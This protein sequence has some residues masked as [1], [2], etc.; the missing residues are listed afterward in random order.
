VARKQDKKQAIKASL[1][2][3]LLIVSWVGLEYGSLL[4]GMDQAAEDYNQGDAEA[5]LKRY[6]DI[7]AR[8]RSFGAFRLIPSGDRR[9]LFLDEARVLYMQGRYDDALERIEREN[10]ISGMISDSRFLLLRSDITFRKATKGS[11]AN[12]DPQTLADAI[13]AAKDDLREALRQDP[14][15]WDAKYN[16]E[17]INFLQNA[18]QKDQQE[19]MKLLPQVPDQ[20]NQTQS[21]LPKQKM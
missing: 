12:E 8:L 19:G 6:D 5:A 18:L 1:G 2:I 20:E 13:G 15:N 3:L 21:L 17:Y 4:R 14:N 10:Q 9:I 7:E 16:Y 11:A